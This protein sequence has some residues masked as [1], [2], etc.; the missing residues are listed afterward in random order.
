MNEDGS[1]LEEIY[2]KLLM[3]LNL[4]GGLVPFVLMG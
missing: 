3:G 4:L 2:F 1:G